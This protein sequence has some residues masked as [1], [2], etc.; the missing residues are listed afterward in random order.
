M[1]LKTLVENTSLNSNYKHKH[2]I[3][4]YIKTQHH[5]ILFDLGQD[6]L[7]LENAKKMGVVIEEIDTVIISHGHMDHAG[8]LKLFLQNN[9]SAK[10]YIRENAFDK[11]YTKLLGLKIN[12]GID[13]SLKE[14]QQV[15]LT[16]Q[17]KVIDDELTLFSD[18]DKKE[19]LST[20]NNS[21]FTKNGNKIYL[22]DFSHEQNLIITEGENKILIAGCSHAGIVNIKSKAEEILKED[23]SHVIAGFH[24]YNPISKRKESNSLVQE[25]SERL[26]NDFTHYYTCH[27][28]GEKAF[29]VLKETLS[30]RIMYLSA[31]SELEI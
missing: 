3:C 26:D 2:G 13:S 27:C 5:Q 17:R 21:L 24:L 15:V 22:D 23:L 31:G 29:T 10:I 16:G 7:F 18:V 28:T 6:G 9:H 12:V 25:I 11:H 4:F 8:A 20:S 30:D 14:H 19:L 1:K